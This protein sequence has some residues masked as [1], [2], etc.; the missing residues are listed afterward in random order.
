M[1][2][3]DAPHVLRDAMV[4]LQPI[5]AQAGQAR[6]RYGECDGFGGPRDATA[7]LSNIHLH[8]DPEGSA[9]RDGGSGCRSRSTGVIDQQAHRRAPHGE[10]R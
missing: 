9:C 6:D 5:E 10:C 3:R 4:A 2:R 8:E 7:A 1:A